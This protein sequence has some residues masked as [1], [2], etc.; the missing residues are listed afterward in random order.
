MP[1]GRLN[2]SPVCSLNG[3]GA[4]R[5]I[6]YV[7]PLLLLPPSG[8]ILQKA[9][10]AA[11]KFISPFWIVTYELYSKIFKGHYLVLHF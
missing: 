11:A 8:E 6:F 9:P 3:L 5:K 4:S 7:K 10:L 1:Q 2:S